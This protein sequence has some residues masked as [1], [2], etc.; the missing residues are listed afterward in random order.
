MTETPH[1]LYD[2]HA[3]TLNRALTAI[4][5]RGYWSAY[6]ESPSPRV[7]GETA[8][9]DG[10][11]AFEAYLGGDFP[12]DQP[13]AADRVATESSPFGVELNVRYPH[14]G[15]DE[16]VAAASAALPAWRDAGP[17]ARAGVCLEILDRLHKHI[18]ELA[19]AVQFTSGQAFVMA[20]QAGGAHALDRALEAVA[21]AYA[22][23]TRH[24]GTAGWEKAAGKG[25]P[26]RMTKTFHVV[27]RGVALVIGC[28]TFPTWNSYPGL[29]ASLVTGNPVVVKPHPRAVL[30]LA[31]TVKYAREVL[32]EAGFDPNLVLLA[33]EAPGE[34]LAST[35]ALHPAVKIIDFTG[36]TEY[37][38]WL[39][40]N[41]RQAAVYTEKAGLNTVVID[42]TDD[43]AGMCRNLGF[44]L[45]LYSGQMCT[46]SQNILIPGNGIETD[47]GHKSFDEVAGGIA[48]AV[49]KVTA[50]PARG[51]EM[52]G[53]I[54]NDGVLERLDEVTK[55]GE[56]VLESR[57]V[58]HP[59]FP[60]AVVRTPTVVRLAADD[61]ATYS[62]EW[63]GPISFAIAT[64][65][66]AHSLE[67]L[68]AT[69][70]EKGA[71]TAAVYST[72]E[73]VLDAAEA[74][75]IEVGVHL[76]CNLTG[77]V[78]V[79]QSAAF[80]DFHGSGANAAAN[81][82]LTDGAYVANRFRIVQS[83]RHA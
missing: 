51:V 65:S 75:A 47:Q 29:F 48:A 52:T 50:D 12:L 39:E 60:G 4:T 78:F 61:T 11:A 71:L 45:S 20:F 38:D 72:D 8:A 83:R 81:S 58:E 34:K 13:G 69:V 33:P 37:G 7:Y 23:M 3:D 5:E 53:A 25:D 68:R 49:A 2:R 10:K 15:A 19:N 14:A 21:Y 18:F 57:T 30:P 56:A 63:F 26:L 43:F 28:N 6:P 9:A 80:S 79:N 32:A 24:P 1:P 54:V 35:L 41:A 22:E 27:P 44:T 36:S 70:G 66:T 46:T 59:A 16:L 62:K 73:A 17:Q 55:V 31:I 82:A 74:A 67:I 40:A 42:S 64:D 76:S 77:G